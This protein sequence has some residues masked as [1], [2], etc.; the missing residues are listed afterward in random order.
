[1]AVW[2]YGTRIATVYDVGTRCRFVWETA[3]AARWGLR[4]RVVGTLMEIDRHG[5]EA[6]NA[7][8]RA[9]LNGLLPEAKLR[10]HYAQAAG[11][12][13]DD[14]FGLLSA[15]GLDT[16]GALIFWDSEAPAPDR[17]GELTRVE[18]R[19]IE[20]LLR[21]ADRYSAGCRGRPR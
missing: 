7:R 8:V 10:T 17:P 5:V 1:L 6:P 16:A 12:D 4:S 20:D 9:F 15:Y 13:P 11:V 3:A 2:L 14:V 21:N 19:A 18:D